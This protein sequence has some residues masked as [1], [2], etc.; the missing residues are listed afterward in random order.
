MQQVLGTCP[1]MIIQFGIPTTVS[2]LNVLYWGKQV[3]E[4]ILTFFLELLILSR[5]LYRVKQSLCSAGEANEFSSLLFFSE[6]I[7]RF[8]YLCLS[9]CFFR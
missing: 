6:S 4:V 8:R 5:S 3:K 7:Q 1:S 9:A 2:A